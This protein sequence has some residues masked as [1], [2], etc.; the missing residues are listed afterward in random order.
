M[1]LWARSDLAA[2]T[3]SA[4]HGGCAKTHSRPAPGG[5]PDPVWQLDCVGGCEDHLR[6]D[7]HWSSTAVEIPETYDET[8]A[9]EKNEKSGKLDRENQLAAAMIELA[10]LGSLPEAIGQALASIAGGI[11]ALAGLLECPDGHAQPAGQKFCG[12]CAAPM[13]ATAA[14]IALPAPV[15][16]A[17]PTADSGTVKLPKLREARL[18][19]LQALA[20]MRNLD[21]EGTRKVLIARLAAAGVT[22]ND[23]AALVAA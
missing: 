11:P 4:A 20:R 2:V 23:Y 8:K 6:H 22:S 3:I 17:E 7:P 5:V 10:K 14:Q 13:R 1:S 21:D 18:E 9:R 19:E 16:A 12:E 15:R